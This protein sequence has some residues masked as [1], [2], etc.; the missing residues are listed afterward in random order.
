MVRDFRAIL[1]ELF[2]VSF[3][4]RFFGILVV[5]VLTDCLTF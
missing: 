1:I 2:L 3:A 4:S 5:I